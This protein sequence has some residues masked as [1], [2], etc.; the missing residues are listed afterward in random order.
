MPTGNALNNSLT[1]AIYCSWHLLCVIALDFAQG[2]QV[3]YKRVCSA[4][5]FVFVTLFFCLAYNNQWAIALYCNFLLFF[6]LYP[7]CWP[8]VPGSLLIIFGI[9]GL[10]FLVLPHCLLFTFVTNRLIIIG[11]VK[12]CHLLIAIVIFLFCFSPN[13]W[14][15]LCVATAF[16]HLL[17]TLSYWPFFFFLCSKYFILWSRLISPIS[18][19][20]NWRIIFSRLN[21]QNGTHGNIITAKLPLL[22]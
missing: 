17:F 2:Q 7:G 19:L 10:A 3:P 18:T 13:N 4:V 15:S 8:I 21:W 22:I 1:S 16:C 20:K 6:T 11:T 12:I 9:L 5:A 14:R